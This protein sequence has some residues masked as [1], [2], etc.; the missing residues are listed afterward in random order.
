MQYRLACADNGTSYFVSYADYPP[1][2]VGPSPQAFLQGDENVSVNGKTLLTDAAINLDGAP[3][4]AFTFTCSYADGSIRSCNVHAFLA[5]TRLYTLTVL[6]PPIPLKG[7]TA[8][9]ADQF[10]NSFRILDNPPSL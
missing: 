2:V 6:S 1:D 5:G 8:S 4:R 3:G 10:M 9:Q 7:D